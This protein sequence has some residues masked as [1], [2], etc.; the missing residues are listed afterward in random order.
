MTTKLKAARIEAGVVTGVIIVPDE[1]T[2]TKFKALLCPDRCAPGWNYDGANFVEPA[3]RGPLEDVDD[4]R[5]ADLVKSACRARILAVVNESAQINVASAAALGTLSEND[6]A[7]YAD[8]VAWIAA[9]RATSA[10]L[11]ANHVLTALEDSS[12]PDPPASFAALAA[13]F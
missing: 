13:R 6:V 10:D 3:P 1:A 7:A 2:A 8:G 9:M 5:F 12:W 11:I 4:E